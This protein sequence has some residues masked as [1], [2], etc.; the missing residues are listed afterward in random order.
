[1][2]GVFPELADVDIETVWHKP[3]AYMLSMMPRIGSLDDKTFYAYGYGGHGI[4]LSHIYGAALAEKVIRQPQAYDF[5]YS[6]SKKE[7][8]QVSQA[9]L[10][11]ISRLLFLG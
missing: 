6:L 1:M 4:A 3:V 2:N 5:L 8:A 11:H 10:Y 7:P 9:M